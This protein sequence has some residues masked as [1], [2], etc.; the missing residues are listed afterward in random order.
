M[1]EFRI[2]EVGLDMIAISYEGF[3]VEIYTYPNCDRPGTSGWNYHCL[4]DDMG[5]LVNRAE[6]IERAKDRLKKIHADS[7][8]CD[9]CHAQHHP[10]ITCRKLEI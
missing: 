10:A 2:T 6:A 4:D 8:P 9:K 5:G 7:L 3:Q 1:N